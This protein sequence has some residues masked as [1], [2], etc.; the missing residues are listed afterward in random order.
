MPGR[1]ILI[2]LARNR[3]RFCSAETIA[4]EIR[5][6][7]RE[8]AAAL[9]ELASRNVLAVRIADAVLYK[10]DPKSK[11]ARAIVREALSESRTG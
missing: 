5:R 2:C 11:D 10:L 9:E 8:V 1:A 4:A 6:P 3:D 7:V